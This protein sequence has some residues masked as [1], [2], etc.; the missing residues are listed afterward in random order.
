MT[1]AEAGGQGTIPEHLSYCGQF[2]LEADTVKA[3]A[4]LPHAK[5][6]KLAE[7]GSGDAC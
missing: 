4:G 1:A 6:S 5:G 3:E 7:C 2:S